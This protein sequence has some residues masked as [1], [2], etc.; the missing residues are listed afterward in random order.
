M[1]EYLLIF[2]GIYSM[3]LFK[4][5]AGPVLG[6]AA[7]FSIIEMVLVTVLGFMTTVVVL[8]YL[9]EFVKSQ[10]KIIFKPKKRFTKTNKRIIRIRRKLSPLA[11][12]FV[13]PFF[14]SP[15]GG[16][17]IMNSLGIKR[18]KI[19]TYMLFSSVFWATF[20]SSLID[21]LLSIP[22]VRDYL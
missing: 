16:T 12:A 4:F 18:R 7:G 21:Q 6:T 17:I 11:I 5:I 9:G 19:L 22:A 10:Y 20:F 15:V 1:T 2:L 14:F 13:A 8:T 3:C